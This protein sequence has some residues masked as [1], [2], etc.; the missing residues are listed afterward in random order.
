MKKLEEL[1]QEEFE[2]LKKSGMLWE[3]FP[4]APNE[5]D[6]LPQANPIWQKILGEKEKIKH[7]QKLIQMWQSECSHDKKHLELKYGSNT[8][9]YD[10]SA[11]SY[12]TNIECKVCG[13]TWHLDGSHYIED[14]EL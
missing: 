6:E 2:S 12:W 10:P 1:N 9:N 5:F 7:S 14:L 11:D 3:I 13:K 4:E 8:G